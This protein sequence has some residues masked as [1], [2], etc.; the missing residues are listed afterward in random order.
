MNTE[1]FEGVL[2]ITEYIAKWNKYHSLK[3][4][5]NTNTNTES[6]SVMTST[7]SEK[8]NMEPKLNNNKNNENIEL[9]IENEKEK[10]KE[11]ANKLNDKS[12]EISEK[13]DKIIDE[14]SGHSLL[15]LQ[16]LHLIYGVIYLPTERQ[17]LVQSDMLVFN[18]A[19][20]LRDNRRTS[21]STFVHRKIEEYVAR[22]LG[23]RSF[24]EAFAEGQTSYKKQKLN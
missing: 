14:T 8:L 3:S 20:W 11:N 22:K 13:D 10:E 17:T 1:D 23:A 15:D 5:T 18:D 7:E 19:N 21:I 4:N 16:P 12:D 2:K 24:R 9:N 6:E